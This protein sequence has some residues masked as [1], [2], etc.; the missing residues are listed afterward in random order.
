MTSVGDEL[1]EMVRMLE[2]LPVEWRDGVV[3]ALDG[4]PRMEQQVPAQSFRSLPS[5][6]DPSRIAV[7]VR[8]VER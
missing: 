2:R 6:E 3:R 7:R 5:L 8:I 4:V 1:G